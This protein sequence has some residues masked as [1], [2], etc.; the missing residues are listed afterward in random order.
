MDAMEP[1]LDSILT[2]A[3][4]PQPEKC[5]V[6]PITTNGVTVVTP[7]TPV[8]GEVVSNEP[9]DAHSTM[10]EN[11]ISYNE[12]LHTLWI[13]CNKDIPEAMMKPLC[14][15]LSKRYPKPPKVPKK[16]KGRKK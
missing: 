7:D 2:V 15:I 8:K 6:S 14:A 3:G 1:S 16:K 12:T 4:L 10:S 5:K 11:S 9:H 13:D